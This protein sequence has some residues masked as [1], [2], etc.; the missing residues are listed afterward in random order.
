[1]TGF[2]NLCGSRNPADWPKTADREVETF[3]VKLQIVVERQFSRRRLM[4]VTI[5]GLM[6][7]GHSQ[8][9]GPFA[10][11]GLLDGDGCVDGLDR[12]VRARDGERH[13]VRAGSRSVGVTVARATAK[14][15]GG[16]E[17]TGHEREH[18]Q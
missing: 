7:T 12:A 15:A 1:M 6:Q 9:S 10:S 5:S 3:E 17:A 14:Q 2:R 13:G 18:Q 16:P 4:L 11:V 8:R